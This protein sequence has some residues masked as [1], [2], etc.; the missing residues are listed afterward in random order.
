[1][2]YLERFNKRMNELIRESAPATISKR[3][4]ISLAS[5]N[6]YIAKGGNPCLDKIDAIEKKMGKNIG[7]AF[8]FDSSARNHSL[9]LPLYDKIDD[10]IKGNVTPESFRTV[11]TCFD[12]DENSICYRITMNSMDPTIKPSDI[13]ML[14]K[15]DHDDFISQ[16]IYLVKSGNGIMMGRVM[17]AEDG[18][19][20][21]LNDNKDYP[22]L[23]L[24]PE[25]ATLEW[26]VVGIERSL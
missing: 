3:T 13:V 6:R 26:K 21:V 7:W 8:G 10:V 9:S 19:I 23:N 12:I 4:G 25:N 5:I 11:S 24:S 15:V 1:M 2:S 18:H 20:N 14:S 22:M 17:I 16:G